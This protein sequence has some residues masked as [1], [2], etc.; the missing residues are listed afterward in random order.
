MIR[1]N[2]CRRLLSFV[3]EAREA[4]VGSLGAARLRG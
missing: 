1:G 4:E 3:L 2:C